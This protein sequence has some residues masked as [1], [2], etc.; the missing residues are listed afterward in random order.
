MCYLLGYAAYD[1]KL[2][3][4]MDYEYLGQFCDAWLTSPGDGKWNPNFDL[5]IP[6]DGIIDFAD[7]AVLA[8]QWTTPQ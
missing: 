1:L 4:T 7:F 5:A 8:A 2:P 3:Y 6:A